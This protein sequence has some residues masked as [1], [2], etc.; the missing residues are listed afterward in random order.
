VY[1]PNAGETIYHQPTKPGMTKQQLSFFKRTIQPEE[2]DEQQYVIVDGNHRFVVWKELYD[3]FLLFFLITYR[4]VKQWP[5]LILMDSKGACPSQEELTTIAYGLNQFHDLY[6]IHMTDAQRFLLLGKVV[7]EHLV[8]TG[9]FEDFATQRL[10]K[11]GKK[12]KI[13]WD[14][15]VRKM[16]NILFSLLII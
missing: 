1:K 2:E 13:D 15:I 4:H 6:A 5:C 7:L 12:E 3:N 10:T 11:G 16:V 8:E 9:L 14:V